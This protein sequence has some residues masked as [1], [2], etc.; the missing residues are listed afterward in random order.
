MDLLVSKTYCSSEALCSCSV[1]GS[2][3]VMVDLDDKIS[4]FNKWL[5][6]NGAK[7]PKIEW[8]SLD[9]TGGVRGAV[10]I[11][12]IATDE[13]MISIPG[14]LMMS[15]PIA[16][17]SD[18]GSYLRQNKD[19]LKTDLLLSVFIMSERSKDKESF[20]Y[21]FLQI[22]PEPGTI[23]SWPDSDLIQLQVLSQFESRA[24]YDLLGER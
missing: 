22:L 14:H 23:S 18:I 10:A 13:A 4:I 21:P 24:R 6:V 2:L 8:P 3:L 17:M 9:T 5:E 7:F 15:P 20:F 1:S 16:Y 19:I 11:E 12:T